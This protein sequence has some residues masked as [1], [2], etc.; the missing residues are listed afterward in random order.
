MAIPGLSTIDRVRKEVERNALGQQFSG[1]AA[2][3][4]HPNA[5]P[6]ISTEV[7]PIV[8]TGP[9]TRSTNSF[10]APAGACTS[11]RSSTSKR[12]PPVPCMST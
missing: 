12:T 6:M 4:A 2:L 11:S 3:E 7:V 5:V 1:R 9:A 8:P 10:S